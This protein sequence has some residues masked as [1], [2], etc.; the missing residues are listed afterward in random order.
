MLL[1]IQLSLAQC[2]RRAGFGSQSPEH[3]RQPFCQPIPGLKSK[4]PSSEKRET[5]E[6]LEFPGLIWISVTVLETKEILGMALGLRKNTTSKNL[7]EF[8]QFW[9]LLWFCSIHVTGERRPW[10]T[11]T[12]LAGCNW[13]IPSLSFSVR[14]KSLK[15]PGTSRKLCQ[16]Y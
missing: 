14:A 3:V 5:Q 8:V 10:S 15:Y 1:R 11:V 12:T 9:Y 2:W 16:V 7:A 6:E 13:T 4:Q